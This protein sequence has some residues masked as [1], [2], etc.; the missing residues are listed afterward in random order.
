MISADAIEAIRSGRR[1][2]H[3]SW[4][5]HVY[6]ARGVRAIGVE[7]FI[8]TVRLNGDAGPTVRAREATALERT[9]EEA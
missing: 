4:R 3:V 7:H 2:V 5:G 9:Y 8:E 6:E 1:G